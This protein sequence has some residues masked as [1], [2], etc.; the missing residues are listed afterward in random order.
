MKS[1]KVIEAIIVLALVLGFVILWAKP[2]PTDRS[3][4]TRSGLSY[5]VDYG[6]GC[7]YI[8]H[9]LGGFM[10]R[11]DAKGQPMCGAK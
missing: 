4:W 11:L 7:E 8:G 6:T 5:Y 2:D 9:F 10:P 1:F 3:F